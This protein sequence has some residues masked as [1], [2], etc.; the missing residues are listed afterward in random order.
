MNDVEKDTAKD[1]AKDT[2]KDFVARAREKAF[3]LY[4]GKRVPH[5]SCGIALAET[6]NLATAPYQCLRRGGITGEGECGAIKAGELIL[7]EYLG[8]PDPIGKVTDQLREA[9]TLYKQEWQRRVDRGPSAGSGTSG[10]PV[11]TVDII[12]NHLT[13]PLGDFMG[14]TRQEFCTNIAAE[15]AEIVAEILVRSGVEIEVSAI[16]GLD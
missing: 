3:I 8:D 2:E 14:P 13:D 11:Q 15:V 7:G 9:I 5:R 1:T 6:F 4:E 16:E 12:C 10:D